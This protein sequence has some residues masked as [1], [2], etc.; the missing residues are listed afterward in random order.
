[1]MRASHSTNRFIVKLF[2]I[3]LVYSLLAFLCVPL[4]TRRVEATSTATKMS[5]GAANRIARDAGRAPRREG[6]LLVRFRE[7][8]VEQEKDAAAAARGARRV[9][10][11]RGGS[12]LEKLRLN[13][14]QSLEAEVAE[15]SSNPAVELVEP[16]YLITPEQAPSDPRFSEQWAL[17]NSGQNGGH[18]DSDIGAQRA[19][20][21]VTG[22]AQTTVAV[23]DSGIDF[24]HPDLVN[25]LWTNP[26]ERANGRDDDRD[27]F[28]DDLHGWDWVTDGNVIVDGQGHG[29]AVAGII[30]AEGNN[31]AG[32]SG[33]MWRAGLMSL[34]VLDNMGTG[35]VADAVEAIDYAVAHGAQVINL[36]WGTEGESQALRDAISRAGAN[37]V[38]V[39]CSAGNSGRNI[40]GSPYYPASFNLPN[41]ISVAASTNV[42]QLAT[43]SNWGAQSVAIA[44]PGS[45]ILTTAPGGYRLVS[46]TS[47]A[48]PVVSGVAGLV[49]ALRPT[50]S[51]V[52]VRAAITGGARRIA[53]LDGVVA[54]GG[55]VSAPGAITAASGLPAGGGN[56]N[57]GNGNGNGNGGNNGGGNGQGAPS[58]SLP[59][60]AQRGSGGRGPGGSFD[61]APPTPTKG[62]PDENLPDLAAARKQTSYTPKAPTFIHSDL[63]PVC[64]VDCGESVEVGGAGGSDPYFATARTDPANTT[65][66]STPTSVVQT[67]EELGSRNFSWQVP[68]VGLMG[69]AGF[70]LGIE[71]NYNSL[72]W[73]KQGSS[74]QYNAD[75]GFPG[76][77][78][79][80]GLPT[81]QPLYTSNIGIPA[82]LMITASGGRVQMLQVGL[83]TY[84]SADGGHTQLTE[85]GDGTR[86][87]RMSDGSQLTFVYNS[88]INEYRCTQIKDRNGNFITINYGAINGDTTLGR[89]TSIIDTLGRQ[90]NFNYDAQSYLASITQTRNGATY[91][92]ATFGYATQL[93]QPNFSGLTVYG[94]NNESIPVL[95]AVGLGDGSSY[96]FDY[97]GWGI[98]NRISHVA[99]DTHTL[100]YASYTFPSNTTAQDDCPRFTERRDWAEYWNGGAEAVTAFSAD[101]NGG[102]TQVTVPDGTSYKV[103]FATSGWQ[104]GLP[105]GTETWSANV[106]QKW[107][108]TNW[109]QDVTAAGNLSVG[110]AGF[111]NP[112]V[113]YGSYQNTPAGSAWSFTADANGSAGL[114]GNNS[115]LTNGNPAAPEGGQVAFLYGVGASETNLALNKPATQSSDGWGGVA[116]RAVDGN[117]SGDWNAGSVTHTN[118]DS[119]AWWQVDLGSVQ[120]INSVKVWNRTDCCSERLANFYVSV[121][122]SPFN[123]TDLNTT[124]GQPGVSNYYTSGQ[125]GSPTSV[126]V[127]R[128][129]RY[130]RVQ[131]SG[132]NYLSLAEVQVMGAGSAGGGATLS[133]SISGFKAGVPYTLNFSAAQRRYSNTG[134]QSFDVYLDD[135]FLGTYYPSSYFYS[136]FSVTFATTPGTHVL[137]FA[138]RNLTKCAFIDAVSISTPGDVRANPRVEEMN[139]Y[140]AVGNRRR[141]RHT[142]HGAEQFNLPYET[143][144]YAADATTPMRSTYVDYNLSPAFISRRIIGLAS[145]VHVV[146]HS[147]GWYVSKTTYDYDWGGEYFATT[148]QTATQHAANN[149]DPSGRGNLVRT[150]RWDVTDINN[151]AKAIEVSRTGYN[152]TGT[153]AFSRDA[154][155]HQSSISYADSFSDGANR[156]TF[157]YPTSITDADNYSSTSQYNYD[158]GAPTR[159]QDPKGMV[160]TTQYD[161]AGRVERVTNQTSTAYTRWFYPASMGY[162]QSFTTQTQPGVEAYSIQ[163]FDG[164]G[165]VREAAAELPG[166]AGGYSAQ[167][168]VYDVMG[169]LVQRS[170]PTEITVGWAPTGDDASGWQW[171]LQ[172]Y[173]WQ[174]RPTLTTSPTGNTVETTYGGCGCAGGE[175]LT[176]RDERGRRRKLYKDISGRLAKVEELNWDQSVYSTT[177]YSYNGRD[178]ITQINQAG[179]L[180]SF[181]YDGHG[182]VASR[183]TPEQGLTTYAYNPDDT[184]QR[185]TD[186]RD[187]TTNFVYNARH[188]VT[189]INYTVPAGVAPTANV[190][191]GYDA[192][193][194][195][196]S[197]T[198]GLGSVSYVYNTLSQM[199]S[200]T[201]TFNGLVGSA[202]MPSGSVTLSYQYNLGGQVTS[203]YNSWNA[204]TVGYQYDAKGALSGVTG[205]GYAGVGTYA[206][207]LRYRAFGA[208]KGMTYGNNRTLALQYDVRQRLTRWDV[209]GVMGYDYFY[210]NAAN[211]TWVVS[212]KAHRVT[213][214][215]NLYNPSLDRSFDYDHLGRL[216]YSHSG[217]EARMHIT[218]Q[219]NDGG[220]YGPYAHHYGYDQWGNINYRA[221]WGGANASYNATYTNNRRNGLT[222]DAAGNVTWDGGQSFAYDATGQQTSAS[223]SGYSLEQ[224]Y[225]GDGLRGRKTENGATTYYLRSSVL[226]DKVICEI[227]QWGGWA[228][229]F[230]YA[231]SQLLAVQYNGVK[232]VHQDPVV[233][234]QRWTDAGGTVTLG[235]ELD[236]WGGDT[237]SSWSQSQ[238]PQRFNSYIRDGNESDEAMYRRYNRWWSR[239]DQPDPYD[240]SYDLAE[241][242]SLN[243]YSY[244]QNDPVNF[245]DP[246]GLYEACVHE[247]MTKFLAKLAGLSDSKASTLGA[248]AGDKPGG[249]D[250]KKYAAT[251]PWNA[252]K[253]LFGKGPSADI[254]FASESKLAKEISRF[255]GYMARGTDQGYQKAAFVLHS[256]QDVHGAHQGFSLPTGHLFAGSTPDRIIGDSKF[257]RAANETFQVLSGNK[258]ASLT[259]QQ[260][261]DLINAI[262]EGCGD[263]AEKLRIV[264]EVPIFSAGGG[265]GG[266]DGGV[267]VGGGG[268]PSW[269][270][271][272][273]D[274]LNW[275]NSIPVGPRYEVTVRIVEEYV[276]TV[277]VLED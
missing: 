81:L 84:E 83:A 94:P 179:Q 159:A 251:S 61:S 231:G 45:D 206:S 242:Q 80:L 114:S 78:F 23:I 42:D 117:T 258:N 255:D 132:A 109:T 73:T 148:P 153:V 191:M 54:S 173:D 2:S 92:W 47:A 9:G 260:V 127:N 182:R 263:E 21:T 13:A 266:G 248:Y 19:W 202:Y 49:K 5:G 172:Q 164:A 253:G 120:Q 204:V 17:A 121:S 160:I 232:Y 141:T 211:P 116:S 57:G 137:K 234:S 155:G 32:I 41:M 102:W 156:N 36:S 177:T 15:L 76:P 74:I 196:T 194:N 52:N 157:A 126:P 3:T 238:Q 189:N 71:L 28:S 91:T 108:A 197:M 223:N 124:L 85:N 64:D 39:V 60:P 25:N 146:D 16:N 38:V 276:V 44:A 63:M 277:T 106:K 129:G 24:T 59:P 170:N 201:R 20:Q 158:T 168:F 222:Y 96:K 53:G 208:L 101:P 29:T 235:I 89:P 199:Q 139:V 275:V 221:G 264:H 210:D 233:K 243:R 112:Y 227:N 270:Y 104:K 34:R 93:V 79:R 86:T 6:E 128:T 256:I 175:V 12:R 180:R 219:P 18:A 225:D 56:G 207:N 257:M 122:D 200:E 31:G 77:G 229:G 22:S 192:A 183:T 111:E 43:W 82:Y 105:T 237:S 246:S 95:T 154:L 69:R 244:V 67:G 26:A 193:G 216:Q 271:S 136:N 273:W 198:D 62:A 217:V 123:S 88:S 240:G 35:D 151:P 226:G 195:R 58:I 100:A 169:R 274:F 144:E 252:F 40:D 162:V 70:H 145:A 166:S 184:M 186:A 163:V 190:S 1:M 65:G 147:I 8:V 68:L 174:G 188:L 11:L 203:M 224:A 87:V 228:R 134:G 118:L 268:L 125:G 150:L 165:R 46:G 181:A 140:D 265:G 66:G 161:A 209:S 215:H 55:V 142:Y 241:P 30:A 10:Q 236:P 267:F 239:F 176:V 110:D 205:A 90:I 214:A 272:M 245:V 51:A 178:Q 33:V 262:I 107:S 97:N 75:H 4:P 72:V 48:A 98:V 119:Q 27:G 99:P 167:K 14:G 187:A 212:D 103:S 220:A 171:T 213:Y 218:G 152:S 230:V 249:A 7:G 149:P 135:R 259:G 138:G 130:V 37:N 133:Q 143:I 247:A 269:Y 115:A 250:S 50:Q 131:L 254:H 261:E 113:G 185:L